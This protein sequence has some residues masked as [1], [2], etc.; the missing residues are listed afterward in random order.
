[1]SSQ[2]PLFTGNK[3]EIPNSL[4]IFLATLIAGFL[5]SVVRTKRSK[6]LQLQYEKIGEINRNNIPNGV[7]LSVRNGMG[8]TSAISSYQDSGAEY[9]MPSGSKKDVTYCV[10]DGRLVDGT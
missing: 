2:H 4:L 7:S 5:I 6:I 1:M 8:T 9:A 3:M 10:I